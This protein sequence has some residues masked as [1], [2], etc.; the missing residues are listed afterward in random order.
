M[1]RFTA[2]LLRMMPP[3]I[4]M[5]PTRM[6]LPSPLAVLTNCASPIV[7]PAPPLLSN[8]VFLTTPALSIA[9]E[10][11]RPVWS[12]PPPGLAG[13]MNFTLSSATADVPT[14]NDAT[15]AQ[16]P[17]NLDTVLII[18][19]R[20]MLWNDIFCGSLLSLAVEGSNYKRQHL[21]I[22]STAT[23][24]C[25]GNGNAQKKCPTLLGHRANRSRRRNAMVLTITRSI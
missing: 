5:P 4:T 18:S 23:T 24:G 19:P 25:R 9:A 17:N 15:N 1:P 13:I 11:L 2:D 21:F 16:A 8:W 6:A 12:Q 20:T 14:I 22:G 7:P 10:K 3:T